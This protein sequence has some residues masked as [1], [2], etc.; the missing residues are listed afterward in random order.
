MKLSDDGV[1]L[2]GARRVLSPNCDDRPEGSDV[3]QL[4]R[5]LD[6]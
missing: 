3:S 5:Q 2:L 6:S 4:K 1:W